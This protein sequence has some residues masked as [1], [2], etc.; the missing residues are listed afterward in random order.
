MAG[1]L[2]GPLAKLKRAEAQLGKLRTEVERVFPRSKRWPVRPET[3]RSG[4]ER[5]FYLLDVPSVEPDWA[6]STGEI[7][8][9]LRAAL[10]YLVY[11]LHLRRFR[12]KLPPGIESRTQFPIFGRESEFREG[13]IASLSQRD[14]RALRN[15]Q[16]YVTRHDQWRQ[17]RYWL[18]HLNALHNVDK[19][20]QLHLVAASQNA[21]TVPKFAPEL[22]FEAYTA[23]GPAKAGDLVETWTFRKVPPSIQPH[24]G[25]RLE[26][27]IQPEGEFAELTLGFLLPVVLSVRKAIERFADRFNG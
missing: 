15:L 23:W 26:V 9:N 27:T 14:R 13:G 24:P 16:P 22:G 6:F 25:A 8:F 1:S 21:T 17:V 12:G 3:D 10:D 18:G 11:E 7:M 4:L 20:R 5:R 19:H 2:E